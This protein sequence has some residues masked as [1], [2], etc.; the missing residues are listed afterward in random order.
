MATWTYNDIEGVLEHITVREKYRDGVLRSRQLL[1]HD[2]Y[3][4]YDTTEELYTDPETGEVYPPIYSY[5]V[6]LP[7][8]SDYM[9]FRAKLIDDTMEVVGGTPTPP[10]TEVM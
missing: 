6:S 3:A 5:Q 2:G 4:I 9:R 8:T 10:E 1:A 7:L